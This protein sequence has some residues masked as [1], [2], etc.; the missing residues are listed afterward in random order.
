ML[1][2]VPTIHYEHKILRRVRHRNVFG[3]AVAREDRD[4]LLSAARLPAGGRVRR[5]NVFGR[6]AARED[7]DSPVSAARR[8]AANDAIVV[9]RSLRLF[10]NRFRQRDAEQAFFHFFN[11]AKTLKKLYI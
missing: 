7:R 11:V 3:R 10:S 8:Q 6:A 2:D 4:S 9:I 5:G 1:T